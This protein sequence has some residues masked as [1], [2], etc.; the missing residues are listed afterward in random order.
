MKVHKREAGKYGPEV[1]ALGLGCLGTSFGHKPD[2]DTLETIGSIRR[3]V[4]LG[5][6]CLRYGQ[7]RL[8]QAADKVLCL[9]TAPR[10]TLLLGSP[11]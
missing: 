1:S 6:V 3:A 4:E 2:Q 5:V 8:K 11:S 7:G 10:P 9:R